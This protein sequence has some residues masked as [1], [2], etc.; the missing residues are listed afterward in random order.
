MGLWGVG[1]VH[2]MNHREIKY[3]KLSLKEA[4]SDILND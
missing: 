3:P 2:G 1:D 4:A